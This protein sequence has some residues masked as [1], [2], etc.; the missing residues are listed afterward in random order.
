MSDYS[1]QNI[2]QVQPETGEIRALLSTTEIFVNS[3]AYDPYKRI[4]YF[5][6][7]DL[8]N[9]SSLT[10]YRIKRMSLDGKIYNDI[11]Y[12]ASSS[13]YKSVEKSL[14]T[15]SDYIQSSFSRMFT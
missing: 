9:S 12:E 3:V 10:K 6:S 2:Y 14:E 7:A 1:Q 15:V 13:K 11:I 8:N 4:V 5:T